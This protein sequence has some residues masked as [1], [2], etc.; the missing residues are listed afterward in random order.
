MAP[1]VYAGGKTTPMLQAVNGGT[2][3]APHAVLATERFDL[4]PLSPEDAPLLAELGADPDVVKTLICDWSTL[5]RRLAI[6]H[7]WIER[8]QEN[9]IW[10]V[11]DRD[12]RFGDIGQ[13]IGFCA[14]DEPLEHVGHGP[15]VYYAFGRQTWGK[16]VATEVVGAVVRHLFRRGDIAAVEAL[17]LAGLNQASC[18][19]L[20]NLGMRLIGRYPLVAY[21]D[22]Q[23]GPT[24]RY[25]LWRV[26]TA[27]SSVALRNLEEAAYKIGQFVAE[28]VGSKEAVTASLSAA[29]QSNGL[30]AQLGE[31]TVMDIIEESLDAGL[32]ETGWLHYRLVRCECPWL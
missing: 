11:F 32:K 6:T 4:K 12:G 8:N 17:V 10:G 2:G 24:I 22:N 18:R 30:I 1:E 25:E 5:D 13:F 3:T 7:G 27:A 21:A 23:C 28:G 26:T 29:A 31:G 16:G 20:E 15:E 19:L 9:G 14:V